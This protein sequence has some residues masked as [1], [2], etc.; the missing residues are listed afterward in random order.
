MLGFPARPDPLVPRI[1]GGEDDIEEV[2]SS[3]VSHRA[4]EMCSTAENER[5]TDLGS[6]I[7]TI[8]IKSGLSAYQSADQ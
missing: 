1:L 8:R 6:Y 4:S 2:A 3:Q 5:L 7:T